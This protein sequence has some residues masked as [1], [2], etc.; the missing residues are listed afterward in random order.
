MAKV[1]LIMPQMGESIVE[2]TVTKWLKAIGDEVKRDESILEISTD[3]VD[4][5]IPSPST[6]VLAEILVEEGV[7]VEVGTVI[8]RLETDASAAAAAAEPASAPAP[9]SVTEP[10]PEPSRF[11]LVG[12]NASAK[13]TAGDGA[14]AVGTRQERLRTRST[15]LVRRI[16]AEHGIDIARLT[17]TGISGRV[18]KKDILAFI[19]RGAPALAAPAPMGR[20]GVLYVPI[21][22]DTLEIKIPDVI[23]KPNDRVEQ[24]GERRAHSA[25]QRRG[26]RARANASVVRA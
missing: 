18:T 23:I 14:P 11:A 2:G 3:K 13:P 16:A 21:H 19:E 24:P 7:T 20:P 6:G 25:H 26:A 10:E 8:A 4:A 12:K 15:P 9:A 5:D 22:G 17:G 1:D